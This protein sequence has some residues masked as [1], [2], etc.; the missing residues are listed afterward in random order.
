[1]ISLVSDFLAQYRRQY[2]FYQSV[3]ECC[4]RQCEQALEASGIRAMVTYRAKRPDR[5]EMKVRRRAEQRNYAALQDM[6]DDIVDLAGVRIALYFPGDRSEVE[7][8]IEQQF[9]LVEPPREFPS[10]TATRRK[11]RFSGYWATHYRLTLR[12]FSLHAGQEDYDSVRIEIQVAS[13]LMHAW[14]EVEH[15]LAY[16]QLNGGLSENE[17]AILDELNGL[18]L[19]GEIALERLQKAVEARVESMNQPFHNHFELAAYLY[20]NLRQ[21][22]QGTAGKPS[23]VM[24]RADL[25]YLLLRH[26]NL[27]QP[28]LI[29]QYLATVRVDDTADAI[30]SQMIAHVLRDH[31]DLAPIYA[32]LQSAERNLD[33]GD[34]D[35]EDGV[36]VAKQTAEP[37]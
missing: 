8:I 21:E 7:R 1:M 27:D 33:D 17:Y 5:V 19:A 9:Q 37:A 26:A 14:A 13:V 16:K 35:L 36:V 11:A 29:S 22:R 31:H 4:A 12:P 30:A 24:G 15:D 3:S 2:S 10:A 18:V 6:Y 34:S 20:E 28:S 32:A 23:L 25:L